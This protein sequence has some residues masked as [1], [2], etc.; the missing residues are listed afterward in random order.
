MGWGSRRA[1]G[2]AAP[3]L[4][5]DNLQP[6]SGVLPSLGGGVLLPLLSSKAK[7]NKNQRVLLIK[8]K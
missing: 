3:S 5:V 7:Q 1:K 4:L 6:A 2:Q 8:A